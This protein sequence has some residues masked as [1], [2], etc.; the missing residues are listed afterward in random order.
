M[1]EDY[2]SVREVFGGFPDSVRRDLGTGIMFLQDG[3]V[4]SDAKPFKT[5]MPGTWELRARDATG[6]YRAI[7]VCIVRDRFMYFIALSK[8][9][10]RRLD[11]IRRPRNFDIDL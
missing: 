10:Q 1:T 3:E 11:L 6:H 7:Y 5:G 8:R 4:P 2:P 9:H